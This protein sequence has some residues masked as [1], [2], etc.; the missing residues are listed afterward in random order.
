[1]AGRPSSYKPEYAEQAYKLCL[2]GA[3]DDE[4]ADFFGVSGTTIDNWK[5]AHP[6]FIGALK[7]G[8]Q[9]ADAN[10]AQSLYHRALGYSHPEDDIRVADGAIVITP[11]VKHYP[12]DSTACIF[13]LKNRKTAKWRDR[14]DQSA[15]E[16][17]ITVTGGFTEDDIAPDTASGA[18]GGI[19]T[20]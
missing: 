1:M 19:P 16:L 5:T 2:L 7:D 3:T 17:K 10:V 9:L 4:L 15:Q 6:Q 12:P 13:W 14:V 18:E 20:T 11:T 8:K